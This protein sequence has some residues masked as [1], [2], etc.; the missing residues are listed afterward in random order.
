MED[1]QRKARQLPTSLEVT[2]EPRACAVCSVNVKQSVL[3]IVLNQPRQ[4]EMCWGGAKGGQQLRQ[5]NLTGHS[6]AGSPM[7]RKFDLCLSV[8]TPPL[9]LLLNVHTSHSVS[10]VSANRSFPWFSCPSHTEQVWGDFSLP[11]ATQNH[12][13]HKPLVLP[14]SRHK[15]RAVKF[16]STS[17]FSWQSFS[18]DSASSRGAQNRLEPA[19]HLHC[20]AFFTKLTAFEVK[21]S[22][23]SCVAGQ[24]M[25]PLLASMWQFVPRSALDRFLPQNWT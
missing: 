24:L 9:L 21:F 13:L 12:P 23:G 20:L 1:L 22:E 2:E 18:Y 25:L 6:H 3:F 17:F 16:S 8:I 14:L 7:K 10:K 19:S 4:G 15:T 11:T 5:R